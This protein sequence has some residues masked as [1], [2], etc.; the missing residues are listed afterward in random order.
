MKCRLFDELHKYAPQDAVL[1][2]NTSSIS[3]SKIAGQI[4]KRAHHVIG[5]HFMN[6]VP[7]MQ[8]IEVI[9]AI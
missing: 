8:L 5:I 9:N 1:A 4:P 2:S 3:I 7:V 6:P